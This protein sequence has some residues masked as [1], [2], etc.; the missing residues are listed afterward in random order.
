MGPSGPGS[1]LQGLGGFLF[2]QVG[3]TSPEVGR[4]ALVPPGAEGLGDVADAKAGTVSGGSTL[5]PFLSLLRGGGPFCSPRARQG[6]GQ[7]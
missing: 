5:L 7:G 1:C 2:L 3:A 6:S 4:T